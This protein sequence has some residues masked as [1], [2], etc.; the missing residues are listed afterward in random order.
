MLKLGPDRLVLIHQSQIGQSTTELL[1]SRQP[2]NMLY[3]LYPTH[4]T[5]YNIHTPTNTYNYT[6][7]QPKRFLP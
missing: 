4:Y 2:D 6:S 1:T 5:M 7:S 3:M